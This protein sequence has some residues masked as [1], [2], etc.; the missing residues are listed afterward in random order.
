MD[1]NRCHVLRCNS[2]VR[3]YK[4]NEINDVV[5]KSVVLANRLF[6][7]EPQLLSPD[8]SGK[9]PDGVT[10]YIWKTSKQMV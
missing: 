2:S 3:R 9:L 5:S 10:P 1:W 4:H 7:G 6:E 8:E